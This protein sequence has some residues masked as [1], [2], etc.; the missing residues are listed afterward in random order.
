[1]VDVATGQR[2]EDFATEGGPAAGL[3]MTWRRGSVPAGWHTPCVV[4]SLTGLLD[5]LT[6][7]DN[8]SNHDENS[9]N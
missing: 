8:E 4:T 6:A 2:I 3:R 9:S 5:C 1:M 7:Q